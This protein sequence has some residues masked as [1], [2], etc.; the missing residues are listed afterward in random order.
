MLY[1]LVIDLANSDWESQVIWN[2]QATGARYYLHQIKI[3]S[4]IYSLQ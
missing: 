4:S 1:N 3:P 2:V